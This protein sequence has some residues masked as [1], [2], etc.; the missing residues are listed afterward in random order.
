MTLRRVCAAPRQWRMR[1][2]II[3]KW[4]I[5][6]TWNIVKYTS[7]PGLRGLWN[8]GDGKYVHLEDTE[9]DNSVDSDLNIEICYAGSRWVE[10]PGD[11]IKCWNVILLALRL[12]SV[13]SVGIVTGYWLDDLRIGGSVSSRPSE[14]QLRL[15]GPLRPPD[16][17]F[18]GG[19]VAEFWP[20]LHTICCSVFEYV[21]TFSVNLPL[22]CSLNINYY[23]FSLRKSKANY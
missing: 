18:L 21:F 9:S 3:T 12:R 19:E 7:Q 23:F 17:S 6:L 15:W 13:L 16:N 10:V 14:H 22:L 11:H 4:Y 1:D 8:T 20:R 2:G 5:V